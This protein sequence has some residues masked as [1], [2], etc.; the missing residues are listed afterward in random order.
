MRV[1]QPAG[2][3][4]GHVAEVNRYPGE[5]ITHP[6]RTATCSSLVVLYPLPHAA[7]PALPSVSAAQQGADIVLHV[8]RP[9]GTDTIRIAPG[10]PA[11]TVEVQSAHD[12]KRHRFASSDV[13]P[14]VR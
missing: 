13:A 4:F 8:E 9:E 10:Q 1:L 11:A 12:G 7:E 5:R 6:A 2:G 3:T 14:V